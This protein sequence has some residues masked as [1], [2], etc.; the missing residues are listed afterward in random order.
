[1]RNLKSWLAL[2]VAGICSF[3][4]LQAERSAP[5]FPTPVQ[6]ESGNNYYLYNVGTG[7]F[8]TSDYYGYPQVGTSGQSLRLT[9]QSD[10][11]FTLQYVADNKYI[12]VFGSSTGCSSNFSNDACFTF[13]ATEG[14]YLIAGK[15]SI[16]QYLGWADGSTSSRIVSNL[17]EGNITWQFL[18]EANYER[19]CAELRLYNALVAMDGAGYNIDSY[20][21]VYADR[22]NRTAEE[23]DNTA[24]LLEN[25]KTLCDNITP[26]AWSE[27]PIL[28]QPVAGEWKLKYSSY[29]TTGDSHTKS[30][31]Q[32]VKGTVVTDQDATLVY[33]ISGSDAGQLEISIDGKVVRTMGNFEQI[34]WGHRYFEEVG[35]GKHEIEWRFTNVPTGS[36]YSIREVGLMATPL[37]SVSL[38]EPGSL[39]TEVLYNVDH[40]KKVRKLKIKGQINDDDWNIINMMSDLFSLDLSE[41]LCT[42][43]KDKQFNEVHKWPFFHAVKLPQNIQTIGYRA[44]YECELEEIDFPASLRTIGDEAFRSCHLKE[45][46]L[47]EAI[48]TLGSSV[49]SYN[50]FLIKAYIPDVVKNIPNT[51][52]GEC[53]FLQEVR[54]PKNLQTISAGAFK[55]CHLLQNIEFP[56][57]LTSIGRD[58]FEKCWSLGDAI[59]LPSNVNSI[60]ENAFSDCRMKYFE[61]P[62][63]INH[64]DFGSR[65]ILSGCSNLETLVLKSPTVVTGEI[66]DLLEGCDVSKVTLRVPSFLVNSYKLDPVW[67][68]YGKIEGFSTADVK[69]WIIQA[70]LVL[71]ARDRFE[72]CPNMKI[73]KGS[74][75]VNGEAAMTFNEFVVNNYADNMNETGKMLS[76]CENIVIE[77]DCYVD[78]RVEANRWYFISLPFN[79]KVADITNNEQALYAI[80]YY[81]GASRA[82]LGTGASWKN[83]TADDVIPAG[84]GFIFQSNKAAWFRFKAQADE[85]KQYIV[86]YEEFA[87][88]LQE[89]PST[90][91]ANKGWNLVGNPYQ[92]FYNIH[93]LNFTAPITLWDV[94]R[95]TYTAYSVIDDDVALQPNQAFFVQCPEE[96]SSITFPLEGRQITS[97]I[98]SQNGV[99]PLNPDGVAARQLIDVQLQQGDF[100][101]RTRVVLNEAAALDYETSRDA[102]KFMSDDASVPQLY[103]LG[104]DGTQYAI[105]ERPESD[106]TVRLGFYAARGGDFTFTLT[107]NAAQQVYLIDHAAGITHD[108]TAGDYHFTAEAGTFDHRFSLSVK[109]F[110][111][112]GISA[113][114]AQGKG[115]ETVEGGIRTNGAAAVYALDGRLVTKLLAGGVAHLPQGIYVV[116]TQEGAVKVSVNR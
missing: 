27:Y 6:P 75:K 13:T 80:R 79:T 100:A 94:S 18:T 25:T 39:G 3:F 47:P 8:L 53:K 95:K 56:E 71:N 69:D 73:G 16:D 14:S 2:L 82:E 66:S 36:N 9:E 15:N 91:S 32:I 40:V 115:V 43:I 83:Y 87:K 35:P 110:A 85:S 108:L 10:G 1:M 74:L 60:E 89:H 31:I 45:I 70:D 107:R 12:E 21:T 38:L 54:L 105:N 44:F 84:T 22:A 51:F 58:A 41:A 5:T 93:R 48:S 96:V 24:V 52:F 99:R 102:A 57:T 97:V 92:T 62:V 17:T 64:W 26:P 67:Y 88:A 112:T 55:Y 65:R 114:D 63:D 42:E 78:Y 116:R 90:N 11:T 59:S 109:A 113:A 29:L 20:E 30:D 86:A 46:K 34:S 104:A 37:I 103:T 19:Y 106:G 81:D 33:N 23:L 61:F 4:T 72:G 111:L 68:N 49:F 50:H 98:E 7:K 28:L 76:N 77:G 101:D